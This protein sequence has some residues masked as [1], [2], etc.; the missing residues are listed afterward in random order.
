M[1]IHM[2]PTKPAFKAQFGWM[3]MLTSAD[4]NRFRLEFGHKFQNIKVEAGPDQT[5][6]P[7]SLPPTIS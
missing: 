6:S 4:G 2:L 1:Q 7:S 5:V 3:D